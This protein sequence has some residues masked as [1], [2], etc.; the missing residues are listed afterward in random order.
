[1][2][3]HNTNIVKRFVFPIEKKTF[4]ECNNT[5]MFYSKKM[6]LVFLIKLL[7]DYQNSNWLFESFNCINEYISL[8]N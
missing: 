3:E 4:I 8:F 6:S 2:V 7:K 1:M 5:F